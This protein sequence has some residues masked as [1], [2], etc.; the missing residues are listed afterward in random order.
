MAEAFAKPGAHARP[1]G[2][3]SRTEMSDRP[4]HAKFYA[5][6]L[7]AKYKHLKELMG[8]HMKYDPNTSC[9]VS[10]NITGRESKNSSR[11]GSKTESEDPDSEPDS[12]ASSVADLIA[13]SLVPKSSAMA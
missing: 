11:S 2:I 7:E 8:N 5:S 10:K 4:G 12:Q 9:Q 6:P 13:E 1:T 3:R